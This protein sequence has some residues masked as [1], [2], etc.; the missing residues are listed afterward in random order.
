VTNPNN[1]LLTA[2]SGMPVGPQ[3]GQP[4]EAQRAQALE[5][6][7][8]MMGSA[9]YVPIMKQL[10]KLGIKPA[11]MPVTFPGDENPRDCIVIPAE[12]L[13]RAEWNYM[14]EQEEVTN[15]L[16]GLI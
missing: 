16:K 9:Q 14:N 12:E 11:T 8:R 13:M 10:G 5:F 1:P 7:A 15:N 3:G 2:N 6:L 4:S